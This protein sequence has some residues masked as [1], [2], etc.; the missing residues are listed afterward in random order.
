MAWCSVKKKSTE[1]T[2]PFTSY[3]TV[4]REMKDVDGL[5]DGYLKCA[6]VSFVLICMKLS[7]SPTFQAGIN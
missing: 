6:A 1:T 7:L 3:S 2:L 5:T 4:V